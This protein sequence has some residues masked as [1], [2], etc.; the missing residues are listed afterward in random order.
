MQTAYKCFNLQNCIF[1]YF[2][3]IIAFLTF[4]KY[5]AAAGASY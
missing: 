2:P 4:H 3:I 1:F 5:F